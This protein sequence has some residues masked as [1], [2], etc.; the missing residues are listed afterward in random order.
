M[1]D[2]TATQAPRGKLLFG[3]LD[4]LRGDILGFFERCEREHGAIVP[5]RLFW[6][7]FFVVNDPD[8]VQA[9]LVTQH[10]NFVKTHGLRILKPMFG[11]GLLTAEHDL[12]RRERS[13]LSPAF[14]RDALAGYST[15]MRRATETFLASWSDGETRDIYEDMTALTLTIVSRS[16]FGT[17]VAEVRDAVSN[18][19]TGVQDFFASFRKHYV[20]I[21]TF[22]P[23]PANVRFKRTVAELDR[24]VYRLIAARRASGERTADVVSALLDA[25]GEDG[26]PMA[27]R[28]IRDELVTLFLAGTETCSNALA[29][30]LYALSGAPHVEEALCEEIDRVLGGRAPGV[31]DLALMPYL[32]RFFK[33]LL[34]LYPTAYIIG[35]IAI[36][37]CTLGGVRVKRGE[38]LLISQWAIHRSSKHYKDPA[39]FMPERWTSEM[40]AKLHKFAYLPFGAGPRVCIGAQF[41]LI[42][43]KTIL[44]GILQRYRLAL[45][46]RA[47]VVPDPAVTLRPLHGLPMIVRRRPSLNVAA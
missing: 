17:D 10:K 4:E 23:T 29:W 39:R 33:E 30:A 19:A 41:G 35:R 45:D 27:D 43:A 44:V 13:L 24:I 32:E 22:V 20:T 40:S 47:N 8:L 15:W 16:L 12:W 1:L 14:R 2:S 18:A 11:E 21:P 37:D 31:D 38:N 9:V 26:R 34:R 36:D 42:E 28:Q 46:P 7:R 25:K 5:L 3:H 6:Y